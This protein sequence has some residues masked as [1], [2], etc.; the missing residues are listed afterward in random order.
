MATVVRAVSAVEATAV[1]VINKADSLVE[2]TSFS[3]V[4]HHALL[5]F[6]GIDPKTLANR[7]AIEEILTTAAHAAQAKILS[8]H[9]HEFGPEQG[10]T[11][12]LLLAESHISIHT[13]PE[14]GMAAL[15]IYLC[16]SKSVSEAIDS[17]RASLK[18][19]RTDERVWQRGTTVS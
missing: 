11:G 16:G 1:G 14:I 10:V 19:T 7:E 2:S 13:W 6:W 15:D 8:S 4:G 5:D 9:F 18:P 12:V 17:L 3:P